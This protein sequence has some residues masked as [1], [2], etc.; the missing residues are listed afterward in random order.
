M[1]RKKISS[2]TT[3]DNKKI[4]N[5]QRLEINGLKFRSKLEAFTY[6]KLLEF[7]IIN[8]NYEVDKFILQESF[9]FPNESY[10]SYERKEQGKLF[11]DVDHNIRALTYLPDFTMI[12]D[13]KTGWIL[14]VK[15]YNNDA[16]IKI[17]GAFKIG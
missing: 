16:S 14:E 13:D 6:N 8:F 10:E 17:G 2:S 5:A 1:N 11:N 12:N 7:G 4:K 3:N 9:E 15:G